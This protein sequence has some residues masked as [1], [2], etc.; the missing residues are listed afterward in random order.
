MV[1]DDAVTAVSGDCGS[2]HSPE[3]CLCTY[4]VYSDTVHKLSHAGYKVLG[5]CWQDQH[6][7]TLGHWGK[8]LD[9][10]LSLGQGNLRGETGQRKSCEWTGAFWELHKIPQ[11]ALGLA[12]ECGEGCCATCRVP[13]R[14]LR[15]PS[16]PSLCLCTCQTPD[17]C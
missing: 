12:V 17:V 1:L 5:G 8:A 11:W 4:V 2:L 13:E 15:N 7:L 6:P 3:S 16:P 10:S 14:Q 9:G